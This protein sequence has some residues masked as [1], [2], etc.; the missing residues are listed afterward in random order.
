MH[1]IIITKKD[2][3]ISLG[4]SLAPMSKEVMSPNELWRC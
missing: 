3:D 1:S 4:Y 2:L